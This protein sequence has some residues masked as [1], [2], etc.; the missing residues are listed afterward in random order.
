MQM[1]TSLQERH[2]NFMEKKDAEAESYLEDSIMDIEDKMMK[3]GF[4]KRRFMEEKK[5]ELS[6]HLIGV[7][8]TLHRVREG[9]REHASTL[10]DKVVGRLEKVYMKVWVRS[11]EFRRRDHVLC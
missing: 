10:L 11:N 3:T 5:Y 4:R 9:E 6:K 2:I 1:N 8:E 7:Q